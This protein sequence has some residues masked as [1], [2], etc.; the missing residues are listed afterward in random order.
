MIILYY[1]VGRPDV[2]TE[3]CDQ[4]ENLAYNFPVL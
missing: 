2:G 3:W 1:M 4:G